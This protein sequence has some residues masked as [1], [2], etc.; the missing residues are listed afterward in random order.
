MAKENKFGRTI[1]S[2]RATGLM[3]GPTAGEDSYMPMGMSIKASGKMIKLMAREF[4][5]KMMG[6][7]ILDSGFRIYSMDL[8]SRGGPTTRLMRGIWFIYTGSTIRDQNRAKGSSHGLTDRFTR[9][10][11]RTT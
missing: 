8:A 9:G 11:F 10:T 6:P 3:I 5:Q 4:I 2:T 7:A 1:R